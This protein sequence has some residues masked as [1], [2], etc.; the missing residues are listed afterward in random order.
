LAH[1]PEQQS[2]F[3]MQVPLSPTQVPMHVPFWQVWP[4]EQTCPQVP[5]LLLSVWVLVQ[6]PE[7]H[8]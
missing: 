7:Q 2:L 6:V 1:S 8:V 3:W 4:L 5:Q